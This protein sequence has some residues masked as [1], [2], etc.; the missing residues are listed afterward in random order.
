MVAAPGAEFGGRRPIAGG[1]IVKLCAFEQAPG[2]RRSATSGEDKTSRQQGQGVDEARCGQATRRGPLPSG[3][4]IKLGIIADI[5]ACVGSAADEHL[6]VGEQAGRVSLARR[7]QLAGQRPGV[8]S[9]VIDF[10]GA[11]LDW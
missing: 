2:V 1:R 11:L 9:W 5:Q 4:V 8:G 3:R 10:G 7:G 6:A